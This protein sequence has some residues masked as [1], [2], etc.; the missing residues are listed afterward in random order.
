MV[1]FAPI[2][3]S[4]ILCLAGT[5]AWSEPSEV[6]MTYRENDPE[7]FEPIV[8]EI[9]VELEEGSRKIEKAMEETDDD[10]ERERLADAFGTAVECHKRAKKIKAPLKGLKDDMEVS[11]EL[12]RALADSPT[13][14]F[15][16]MSTESAIGF[17]EEGTKE[18]E[19]G[20]KQLLDELEETNDE[21]FIG[22]KIQRLGKMQDTLEPAKETLE[23]VKALDKELAGL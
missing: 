22:P 3:L 12:R 11:G 4:F 15:V 21:K 14:E 1:K 9:I 5:A 20:E 2:A 6:Q 17:L 8:D 13:H 7:S 10:D 16:G 18:L 19:A 23:C